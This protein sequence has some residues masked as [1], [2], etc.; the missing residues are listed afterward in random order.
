M[1]P[2]GSAAPSFHTGDVTPAGEG[3]SVAPA[4]LHPH[5]DGVPGHPFQ[6]TFPTSLTYMYIQKH[7]CQCQEKK[8]DLLE[9]IL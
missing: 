9:G 5:T 8:K 3:T 1:T 2:A 7:H 6:V 4:H